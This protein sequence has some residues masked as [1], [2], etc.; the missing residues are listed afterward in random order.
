MTI[1]ICCEDVQE[2]GVDM[3]T[4]TKQEYHFT[5]ESQGEDEFKRYLQGILRGDHHEVD[6]STTTGSQDL[7]SRY[8]DTELAWMYSRANH[9]TN[10]RTNHSTNHRANHPTNHRAN[11]R[12]NYRTNHRTDYRTDYHTHHATV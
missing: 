5:V 12:T 3:T 6:C 2:E 11:Y 9:P 4:V 1:V 7:D 10:R 8:T